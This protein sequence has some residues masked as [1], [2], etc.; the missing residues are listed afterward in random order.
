MNSAFDGTPAVS[1]GNSMQYPGGAMLP[2]GGL[3]RSSVPAAPLHAG[4]GDGPQRPTR[5]CSMSNPWVEEPGRISTAD[6]IAVAL[7]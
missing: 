2:F 3:V 4:C 5:R 1:S 7:V 6:P